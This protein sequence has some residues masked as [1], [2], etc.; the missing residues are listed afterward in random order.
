MP[1]EFI[2]ICFFEV[3]RSGGKIMD[4]R[5]SSFGINYMKCTTT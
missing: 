4:T 1:L 3:V 5:D 2:R